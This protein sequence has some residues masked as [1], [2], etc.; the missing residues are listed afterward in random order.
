MS[1]HNQEV[2]AGRVTQ[3]LSVCQV[4]VLPRPGV[5]RVTRLILKDLLVCMEE[6]PFLRHSLTLYKAML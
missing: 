1:Q 2:H 3:K 5:H 4:C 6:E